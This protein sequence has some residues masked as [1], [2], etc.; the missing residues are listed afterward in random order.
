MSPFYYDAVNTITDERLSEVWLILA[1]GFALFVTGAACAGRRAAP[2][3][4]P[5][6]RSLTHA[7]FILIGLGGLTVAVLL[8]LLDLQ[9]GLF[10]NVAAVS[11]V[12]IAGAS[13]LERRNPGTARF[14]SIVLAI[15]AVLIG[16]QIGSKEAALLPGAAW[17]IGRLLAGGRIRYRYIALSAILL[18]LAF[19]A[20]Q[21]Q[22]SSTAYNRPIAG[23]A[24]ALV[25]G[26]TEFDMATG[27][28]QR[29]EG[30]GIVRN[31]FK[32][33]LFRLK[34]A[35][36]FIAVSDRVPA[37]VPYQR[38]R[39]LWQPAVSAVPGNSLLF[40]IQPEYR[41]LSLGRFVTQTFI[42]DS[43]VNN[44]SAQSMTY[45]GDFYLNF[46]SLGVL[47]GMAILGYLFRLLDNNIQL[48]DAMTAG[49][50][51]FVGLTLVAV[52]RNIAYVLVTSAIRVVVLN[53]ILALLL[54]AGRK[55]R[56]SRSPTILPCTVDA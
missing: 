36:Y 13:F 27:L 41:Q 21:G 55:R 52:D 12:G 17:L 19:G 45:P 43:S 11:V 24:G 2:R 5:Q 8:R 37:P 56:S 48:Q 28:P 38:G 46:G 42:S 16:Y 25:A 54:S 22:R 35:D 9:S 15:T 40:D 14:P 30:L 6:Y 1:G 34:G 44:D 32:G 23:P 51:S 7:Q 4:L 3:V 26:L 18:S 47:L 39:S 20:V 10:S 31:V 50:L 53:V 33:V 49:F 29:Y